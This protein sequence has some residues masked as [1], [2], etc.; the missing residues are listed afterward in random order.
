MRSHILD[1]MMDLDTQQKFRNL[2]TDCINRVINI[3][4][5]I[6]RYQNTLSLAGVNLDF[7]FGIGLYMAL[8][9]MLLDMSRNIAQNNNEIREA[10]EDLNFGKNE[11]INAK[12]IPLNHSNDTGEKSVVVP[13]QSKTKPSSTT[14]TLHRQ[15][16]N[17]YLAQAHLVQAHLA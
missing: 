2:V 16:V 11:N 10:T 14:D 1:S 5:D 12:E 9:N 8:S 17:Q 13:Q 15:R 4:A 6:L 7:V 3:S